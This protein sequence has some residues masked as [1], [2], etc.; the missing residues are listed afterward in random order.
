[1]CVG[2]RELVVYLNS[3]GGFAISEFLLLVYIKVS[4][5]VA[6]SQ[7]KLFRSNLLKRIFSVCIED[8]V[9]KVDLRTK[10]NDF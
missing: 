6:K 3:D 10:I 4:R 5:K 2:I 1:M 7:R 8:L 9:L